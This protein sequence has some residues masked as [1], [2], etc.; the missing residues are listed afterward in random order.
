MTFVSSS[1]NFSVASMA[2]CAASFGSLSE[3]RKASLPH[4]SYSASVSAHACLMSRSPSPSKRRGSAES[5]GC[6]DSTSM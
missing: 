2:S 4:S 6:V 3:R 1:E 5:I